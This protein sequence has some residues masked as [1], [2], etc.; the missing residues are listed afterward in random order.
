M[1][2]SVW[3]LV[4]FTA[5]GYA[6]GAA[7]VDNIATKQECEKAMAAI[8]EAMGADSFGRST[9]AACIEVKKSQS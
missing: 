2:L 1:T 3:V 9:R 5:S 6:G 8:K 4:F 7:T